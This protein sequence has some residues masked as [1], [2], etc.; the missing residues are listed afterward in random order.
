M[1]RSIFHGTSLQEGN[2]TFRLQNEALK[3]GIKLVR[4][5]YA[6]IDD[7]FRDFKGVTALFNCTGLGSYRLGGVEDHNLY[8]T[9]VITMNVSNAYTN[10]AR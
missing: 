3:Q 5:E 7:V 10:R 4:R 6:H 8:P 1:F 2:L 9:K